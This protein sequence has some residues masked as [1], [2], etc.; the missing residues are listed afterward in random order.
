MRIGIIIPA[1]T[2]TAPVKIARAIGDSYKEVGHEVIYYY[3]GN[4]AGKSSL[5]LDETTQRMSIWYNTDLDE[6][7]ILH[8]HC[9]RPDVYTSLYRRFIKCAVI[10]TLHNDINDYV[11]Y[12]LSLFKRVIYPKLWFRSL[13]YKDVVV[14]L[15]ETMKKT[16]PANYTNDIVVINNGISQK[17][18]DQ[19]KKDRHISKGLERMAIV[20]IC[21][22]TKVKGVHQAILATEKDSAIHLDIYGDGPLFSRLND[23]AN[24]QGGNVQFHGFVEE[25]NQYLDRYDILLITSYSEGLPL[26][27]LEGMRAG[28]PIVCP[29]I[30]VFEELLDEEICCY[31]QL[32]NIDSL[33]TALRKAKRE[34]DELGSK[35][36]AA[37]LARFTSQKMSSK[38]IE[39]INR[40]QVKT[41]YG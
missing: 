36:R 8:T 16:L 30:A 14:C 34:K 10:S 12:D 18:K 35:T 21:G 25:A 38:Y 27:L 24:S 23:L 4:E 3:W 29:R 26:T 28:I 13:R 22:L 37:F 17:E 40:L 1:L 32:N 6:C 7:D 19:P 41:H 5:W 2:N 39:V 9:L 20:M 31:Y 33:I 11:K 15:T